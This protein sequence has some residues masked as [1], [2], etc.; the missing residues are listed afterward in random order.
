MERDC[1]ESQSQQLCTTGVL[2][3]VFDTAALLIRSNFC[4]FVRICGFSESYDA[5]VARREV[6]SRSISSTRF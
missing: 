3:L 6:S 1:A 5:A 2:R 4:R